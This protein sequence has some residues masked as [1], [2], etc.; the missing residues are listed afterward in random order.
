MFWLVLLTGVL[1]GLAGVGLLA[2]LRVL[3][4]WLWPGP[5]F[6]AAVAAAR[7]AHRIV[8]LFIAGV[9]TTAVRLILHRPQNGA[10]GILVSLWERAG[11]IPL[12]KT[13]A[14]TLL[15]IVDL[16]LGAALG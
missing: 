6:G 10:G 8:A 16:S 12:G 7:P 5:T 13:L 9:L 14:H 4:Q 3:E 11:I 1:S 15:S 2:L